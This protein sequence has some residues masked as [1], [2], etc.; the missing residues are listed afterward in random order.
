MPQ[1]KSLAEFAAASP[2]L[3]RDQREVLIDQALVL[4]EQNYVHLPLKV[5]MHAVNPVQRLRLLRARLA[6]QTDQT[7]DPEWQF[8]R[9]MSATFH[10]VRDL[11]TN[12]LLPEP[13]AGKVAFL[14]FRVERCFTTD[15][16][17]RFLVTKLTQGF[18]PPAGFAPGAEVTHWNGTPIA[19]AA[20][21]NGEQF[22]GSNPT[23]NFAR[24]LDSLTLR[25]LLIQLPPD[26]H[27]VTVTYL[28]AAGHT[29]QLRQPWLVQDVTPVDS[30]TDATTAVAMDLDSELKTRA[31]VDLFESRV[32]DQDISSIL[33]TV[34]RARAVETA[35]GTF[36]HLRVFTFHTEPAGFRAEFVRLLGLLPQNGLIVDV[37]DNGGGYLAASEKTLQ[38]LTPRRIQPEPAQILATALNLKLC[39]DGGLPRWVPSLDQATETGATHSVALPITSD[40]DANDIGQLYHGPVVL[41]TDALCYSATDIFAAGF[42]DHEIGVILGIDDNTGAGGATVLE[43][44]VLAS[45]LHDDPDTPYKQLPNG[46]NMRVAFERMLRVGKLAG[47]PLEDVGVR[48]DHVHRMTRDDLLD[49][50]V[51]LLD[52]AGKL[53]AGQVVRR[54]VAAVSL[55]GRELTVDLDTANIDRA[56]FYLDGRPVDSLSLPGQPLSTTVSGVA[57]GQRFRIEGFADGRLV[58]ARQ[59]T[60]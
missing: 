36:G 25:P 40:E 11:H 55:T 29:Q 47:T 3:T 51:D 15:G 35:H 7:M 19:R 59:F 60:T 43:Q 53:L 38:T 28:D 33:P 23:A 48:P 45:V 6:R 12:Y 17:A 52:E 58:A 30:E 21:L 44:P 4:F 22:A 9:D 8:H 50:N 18:T 34:F 49:D 20:A 39:R 31:R 37:R 56:D 26:E 10:A 27:W 5:A 57:P 42:A 41:I 54:L 1:A 13:Y 14:P 16:R 24:G 2:A 46:A 32:A